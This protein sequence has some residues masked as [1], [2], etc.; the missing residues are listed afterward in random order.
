MET[1][2][3][4]IKSSEK[5]LFGINHYVVKEAAKWKKNPKFGSQKSALLWLKNRNVSET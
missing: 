4:Q 3:F 1:V 2:T 5:Y